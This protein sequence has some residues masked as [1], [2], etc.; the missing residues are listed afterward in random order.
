MLIGGKC[1]GGEELD[2]NRLI[3]EKGHFVFT[4]DVNH[5]GDQLFVFTGGHGNGELLKGRSLDASIVGQAFEVEAGLDDFGVE[6]LP[7]DRAFVFQID[8]FP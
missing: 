4:L 7:G 8:F 5:F 6:L 1:L 2:L 3:S